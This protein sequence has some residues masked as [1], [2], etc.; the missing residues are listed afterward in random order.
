MKRLVVALALITGVY[1]MVVVGRVFAMFGIY[2]SP[3]T[4]RA[5]SLLLA[6]CLLFLLFPSRKKAKGIAWYDVI[7]LLLGVI[8]LAFAAIFG[9]QM[10]YYAALG[11]TDLK[12]TIL[13]FALLVALLEGCRRASNGFILPAILVVALL[14]IMFGNY[15]PSIFH[16]MGFPARDIAFILYVGPSGLFG[17]PLRVAATIIIMY[18]IF[19]Q[20]LIEI[21][22][23]DWFINIALSLVGEM[24]GGA[25]KASIVGSALFGTI[26]GAPSANAAAIGTI[27]IPLMKKVGYTPDFAAGVEAVA[28]TGGQLMPPVMGSAAFIMAAWLQIRY[29][30]VCLAATIPAILYFAVLF[31]GVHVEA[32]KKNLK[33]ISSQEI[34]PFG[35]ALKAGWYYIVPLAVLIYL[36]V[37][38]QYSPE[39]SAFYSILVIILLS[40]FI[41]RQTKQ[42]SLPSLTEAGTRLKNV[43]LSIGSGTRL[44]VRIA[45]ICASVGVLVGGLT[46]SGISINM[47]S[48]VVHFSGGQLL[49]VLVLTAIAAYVLGMGMDT[50]P[51]YITLALLVAP[52]LIKMGVAPIAAHLYV[53][54]WGLTS[55]FTPPVCLA[56]FITSSIAQSGVWRTGLQAMRLGVVLFVV[57]FA[58]IYFPAILLPAP[59]GAFFLSL[60]RTIIVCIGI[61]GGLSGFMVKR[62]NWIMRAILI[63]GGVMVLFPSWQIAMPG[64]ILVVVTCLFQWFT[65]KETA[66]D[67]ETNLKGEIN[68]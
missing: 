19:S 57:P 16:T 68:P 20:L 64:I 17:I 23:S 61:L 30:D 21:G 32:T 55:F 51:L 50:L 33:G 31:Y 62:A 25:A 13:A 26:S 9:D 2:V 42:L 53:Y 63:V 65:R 35:K 37:F 34:P 22:G 45:V 40:V 7:L 44:W 56:V 4:H 67:G 14:V 29:V 11:T 38:R 48:F 10:N 43:F 59:P 1:H 36:L 54:M 39:M 49:P 27:T 28:S 58:L 8:P 15:M 46:E 41:D 12:G 3:I 6:L 18:V 47:A 5:V 66:T 24:K 52:A 60:G